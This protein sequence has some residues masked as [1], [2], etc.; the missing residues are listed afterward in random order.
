MRLDACFL[1]NIFMNMKSLQEEEAYLRHR[2]PITGV[3]S[4]LPI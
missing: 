1:S 2:H 3:P 4:K